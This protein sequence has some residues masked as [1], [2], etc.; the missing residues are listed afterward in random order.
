MRLP[1]GA[2][3]VGPSSSPDA[4]VMVTVRVYEVTISACVWV[5]AMFG[6]AV[7]PVVPVRALD[8]CLAAVPWSDGLA[9]STPLSVAR[10]LALSVTSAPRSCDVP[11]ASSRAVVR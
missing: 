4:S 3:A 2:V 10:R 8:R 9:T 6:I 11:L 5:V 1:T 7:L